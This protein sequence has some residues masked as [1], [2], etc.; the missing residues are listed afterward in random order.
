M[1][2]TSPDNQLLVMTH[3]GPKGSATTQ[4]KTSKF[5]EGIISF[6]STHLAEFLRDN[7]ERV[8]VNVHGHAHEGTALDKIL[9]VRVINPGSLMFGEY[10]LLRLER[11]LENRWKIASF[12][13]TLL[14]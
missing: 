13:K 9:R 14:A 6:G 5:T 12:T 4:D 7:Q 10:G 8:V 2:I 11:N 1:K 3:D